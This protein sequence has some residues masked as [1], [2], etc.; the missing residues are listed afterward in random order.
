MDAEVKRLARG[1]SALNGLA[2]A[3]GG[4]A[5][6]FAL[7]LIPRLAGG[8]LAPAPLFVTLGLILVSV[9]VATVAWSTARH[10]ML[11]LTLRLGM[12]HPQV[13][14]LRREAH[15]RRMWACLIGAFLL[16]A[17]LIPQAWPQHPVAALAIGLLCAS[18]AG[19]QIA[20]HIGLRRP[21]GAACPPWH[22]GPS[23]TRPGAS[24]LRR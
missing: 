24:A 22:C 12:D 9:V 18:L 11:S 14:R 16:P 8:S 15:N 5:G 6:V 2:L 20:R 21:I 3:A 7:G 19:L 23:S 17:A 4:L 13:W 1:G 10:S